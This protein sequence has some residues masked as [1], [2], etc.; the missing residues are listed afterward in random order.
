M[1]TI[2]LSPG[3]NRWHK[4]DAT[5]HGPSDADFLAALVDA[6]FVAFTGP[7]GLCGGKS[8]TRSVVVIHR[9]GGMKWEVVFREHDTDMVTAMTTNLPAATAFS[10]TWLRG[11]ALALGE[12]SLHSI[13]R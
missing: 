7:S 12:G 8:E 1:S 13:A 10:L 2:E 6:G 5:K 9:G 4:G 3:C 11:E